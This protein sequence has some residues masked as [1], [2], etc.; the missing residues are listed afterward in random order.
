MPGAKCK[1]CVSQERARAESAI[2]LGE[3]VRSVARR[4][5]LPYASLD[6][7]QRN[8]VPKA[9]ARVR[10]R[11]AA[12]RE[13]HVAN[14]QQAAASLEADLGAALVSRVERLQ[15]ITDSIIE[16]AMRSAPAT[17]VSEAVKPD[18]EL[19]LKAVAQAR[20]NLELIGRLT[21]TL[22]PSENKGV[23][24]ITFES[25]EVLYKRVRMGKP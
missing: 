3:S 23:Q 6:R 9:I 11:V 13:E 10:N 19:A 20:R 18:H 7:H 24:L 15:A 16:S 21:G 22:E 5:G 2:A 4:L 17:D 25:F 12:K 14:V 8:C 1:I